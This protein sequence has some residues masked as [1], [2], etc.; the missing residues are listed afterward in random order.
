[1]QV[2]P[3]LRIFP[4]KYYFR[5]CLPNFMTNFEKHWSSIFRRFEH[6][7]LISGTFGTIMTVLAEGFISC[8]ALNNIQG[9][10]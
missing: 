1:M 10:V 8:R 4:D 2:W 9:P 3:V 7:E 5:I 6:F